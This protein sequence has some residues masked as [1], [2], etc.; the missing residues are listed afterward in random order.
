MIESTAHTLR[1]LWAIA[2]NTFRAAVRNK[3][4][5]ALLAFAAG[6][7]AFSLV[8]GSM[9]LHNEVRV[10]TDV[11]LF[12]STL[13][14][15]IITIYVSINLLVTEIERHTIYTILSKPVERWQFILG[16]FGGIMLLDAVL[17]VLLF[18]LSCGL[19]TFEGGEIPVTFGWAFLLIYCQLLIVGA[20]SLVFAS[21]SSPLLSGLFAFGLFVAGHLYDQLE[22]VASF[23]EVTVIE[24]LVGFLQLLVPNLSSLNI[25]TEVVHEM[26]IPTSYLLHAG[27]YTISYTAA[28]LFVAVVI[29][30]YRDLL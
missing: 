21:F 8:L 26:A 23:F 18:G 2:L 28:A 10:A 1:A 19:R 25:A 12:A 6:T 14:S 11:A 4:L 3:I 17:V 16:K 29:F 13:F 7:L 22:T 27:W 5:G 24:Q 30:S 20:I 9:S 15:V